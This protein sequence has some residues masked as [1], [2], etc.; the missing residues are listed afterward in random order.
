MQTAYG[1]RLSQ[2]TRKECHQ[3]D[4]MVLRV[5]LPLLK[6]N[7]S[8]PRTMV[9]GPIQFGGMSMLKHSALQDEWGIHNAVMTLR[10]DDITA[11]D[12]LTVIDAYQ[13]VSGFITPVLRSPAIPI[14]YVGQGLIAHL[15]DRLRALDGQLAV[16]K[17]WQPSLQRVGDDSIMEPIAASK[18][19]KRIERKLANECR[20]WLRV[21]CLSDL[22]TANGV[23]IPFERL[24]GRWRARKLPNMTWPDLPQPTKKHW[25]AFRKC[26]RHTCCT[27]VSPYRQG[28]YLLDEPLG[29]WFVRPRTSLHEC[30]TSREGIFWRDDVGCYRC[31]ASATTNF[32][33][34]DYDDPSEPPEESHPISARYMTEGRLWIWK[35]FH[36]YEFAEPADHDEVLADEFD[37]TPIQLLNIVSDASV[38]VA[39]GKVAGAWHILEEHNKK[40]RVARSL[41]HQR[42]AHSY[43]HELETFYHALKDAEDR[44]IHPHNIIQR[45]DNEGGLISLAKPIRAPRDTMRTDMDL[46][47]A[48]NELRDNSKHVI[49]HEWVMG[50]ADVKKKDKPETITPWEHENIECDEEADEKVERMDSEGKTPPPFEPLPGYRAMLKLGDNWITTHFREC[51]NFANTSPAMI[52]YVLRRLN[53]DL[54]TFHTINWTSIGR[55]RATHRI[56]RIVRTSKMM[57]RWMA[58]G[59]NWTKCN[60]PSDKCPCC[61]AND[62]TF[63]HLLRCPHEDLVSVRK[64][65]YKTIRDECKLKEVPPYFVTTLL[66]TIKMVLEGGNEPTIESSEALKSALEAQKK[67]G[68]YN[69]VVGFMANEWT[70]ALEASGAEHPQTMMEM[71]LALIWDEICER[72]WEARNNILHSDKNHVKQDDMSILESN[73]LW[74]KR[75]QEEVLDYRHRF[76]ADFSA[77]DVGKWSR[78][79]RRAKVELLNNARKYYETE[80]NQRA[81]NQSTIFD[82]LHSYTILRSGRI[83]G[84]GLTDSWVAGRRP[85]TFAPTYDYDSDDSEY[86]FD[87]D[88]ESHT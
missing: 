45:M 24:S 70:T 61:G 88:P 18:T 60:L 29:Q 80:C 56:H 2:F 62:E 16:E 38:H 75:H 9:H 58:V 85:E 79:T 68:L 23:G 67:I 34:V 72:L 84:E 83:L 27:K 74:Y 63:E 87:W 7:R 77:E 5:F 12:M 43:R 64:E 55:V 76:L 42:H 54:E 13:L 86:E 73:L 71:I 30:Y 10:W 49:T 8:S 21:P 1:M 14:D 44:L 32:Y 51:V 78:A 19:I 20:L 37:E 65:A 39:A 40:R 81:R 53:I 57:F 50:H 26:L 36:P 48:Y 17:A 22:T 11:R 3:L 66:A 28:F 82:W 31:K 41:E 33:T 69:M 25:A 52:E 59:H 46:V 15:R 4:V 35:Q 6:I 47:M